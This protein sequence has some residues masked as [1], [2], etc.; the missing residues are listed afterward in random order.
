MSKNQN[1]KDSKIIMVKP[2]D[3]EIEPGELP[4]DQPGSDQLPGDPPG[5]EAEIID[6]LDQENVKD[7]FA[8]FEGLLPEGVEYAIYKI[9]REGKWNFV[10]FT[11]P[12]CSIQFI[13][14]KFG[15][16]KYLI[17]ARNP[18]NGQYIKKK[19]IRISKEVW[20]DMIPEDSND[21]GGD[22]EKAILEKMKIYKELFDSSS[23][24]D[25]Q[26]MDAMNKQM[27]AMMT[28]S[29]N[30]M[31]QNMEMMKQFNEAIQDQGSDV[32]AIAGLIDKVLGGKISLLPKKDK[33]K[34][35]KDKA[36]AAE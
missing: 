8:E 6:D 30:M 20:G 12:P 15:G 16:G 5:S 29:N 26:F 22:P 11:Q 17:N 32:E 31:I 33:E 25:T 10:T 3:P 4:G 21:Q 24:I 27:A 13:A 7:V 36:A 2:N 1:K 34:K 19:Q 23:K 35:P 18:V 9:D 14:E 28:M